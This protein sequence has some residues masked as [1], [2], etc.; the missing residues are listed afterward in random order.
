MNT[1]D[2]LENAKFLAEKEKA[3]KKAMEEHKPMFKEL[4]KRK[5]AEVKK[6]FKKNMKELEALALKELQD[7]SKNQ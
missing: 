3:I 4:K 1:Y 2:D 6:E 7:E 5:S